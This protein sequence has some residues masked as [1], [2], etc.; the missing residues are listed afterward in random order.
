MVADGIPQEVT[1][2]FC[3]TLDIFVPECLHQF[4]LSAGIEGIGKQ[5]R[6]SILKYPGNFRIWNP[7]CCLLTSGSRIGQR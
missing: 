3:G 6:H 4:F 1:E 7:Q 5:L 2:Q